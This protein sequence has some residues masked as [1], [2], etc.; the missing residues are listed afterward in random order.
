MNTNTSE[1]AYWTFRAQTDY[2]KV[3]AKKHEVTATAGF[4]FRESKTKTYGNLLL[5]Y[6]PQTQTNSNGMVN[7]GEL[8]DL[9]GSVSA[10][11]PNYTMYGAPDASGFTTSDVL[12]R[13]YSLYVMGNYVYDRR[14][15]ASFS[16]RVDKTDL[17]GADPEFRG[18]PL[19]SVGL[20]WNIHNEDFMKQYTWVDALKLRA[21][22]GLT[23][24]IDQTISSYLTATIANNYVNG[25]KY[26]SLNTPP[27]DQLR[28]EK[29]AS[30]NLGVDFS[31]WQNSLSGSLD[32]Y[33]KEG[34]DLLT[35][36]DLDPTTGWTQLT[37]N[38]GE[39]LNT[40]FEL[41]LNGTIL[42]PASRDGLGINAS[43]NF[44]YNK[45]EVTSVNHE[46]TSGAEALKSTT[47]HVG[48]PIHSLFSYRHA[49]LES[50]GNMQF[51]KWYDSKGE[52]H[53]SSISS[54][55]FTVE[56]A[57][58]S[59]S[60]DPKYIASFTPELTYKGFTL[61]AMFSYYGG[62][63][64]RAHTADWTSDGNM[65]G[66]KFPTNLESFPKSY[67]NY[68]RTGDKTRY[69][70]NGYLS[71]NVTGRFNTQFMDANVVP[72]DYMKLRNLV[73]GYNFN[74]SICQTLGVNELRLR[75]QMN[76]LVTWE[77]NNVG[78]DPE[79]NNPYTGIPLKET[80]RSY[81]MSLFINL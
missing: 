62:H 16:Y 67:L 8:K 15:S 45:N 80:P 22:Y 1:G 5:G 79:A 47:F 61:S 14:Y 51:Y 56:D 4:E 76:N 65:Y 20:S 55:E 77:R 32:L 40:G 25:D 50:E 18:R 46:P 57:V 37:I 71:E 36:T 54:D 43:L 53:K 60:L 59:G 6:D 21:S 74:K 69:P 31:L 17:F 12:H 81:T 19:W 49:G 44:A 66:Y 33:R 39:A 68:W 23:G 35:V 7:M 29:T 24:N 30:W 28:W 9:S 38:N 10:L 2:S 27:N 48:Y 75:I 70:A 52:V 13:F 73:I 26:A 11:G 64:M 63:H 72:A 3:F 78:I 41:Q 58:Y 42:R 34:S